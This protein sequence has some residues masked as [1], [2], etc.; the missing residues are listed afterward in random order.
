M[1]FLKKINRFLNSPTSS[2]KRYEEFLRKNG[3]EIG[4]NPRFYEPKT[5]HLDVSKSM[6]I[7]LGDN[8]QITRGVIILAHDWSYSVLNELYGELPKKQ[9]RTIIG[10]NVFIGMNSIILMGREIGDN[11]I[12]GAGSVVSGKIPS[13]TVWSGNPAHQIMSL[14]TYYINRKKKFIESAK[15]QAKIIYKT[16]NRYPKK[17]EMDYFQVL[18][19]ERTKENEAY[20]KNS[21]P[22]S[23]QKFMQ[24]KIEFSSFEEFLNSIDFSSEL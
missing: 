3:M 4:E 10:N 23:P 14:E 20:L 11:V 13:N 1:G 24:T 8:V 21:L 15:L 5:L 12:I 17:E 16:K 22:K 2:E 7:K 18:F 9:E 6:Y 19:L